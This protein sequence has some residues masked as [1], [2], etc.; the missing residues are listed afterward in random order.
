MVWN[1]RIRPIRSCLIQQV[2]VG[3]TTVRTAPLSQQVRNFDSKIPLVRG[4]PKTPP[5]VERIPPLQSV[6]PLV[7]K[8]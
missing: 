4:P 7:P 2:F 8:G 6:F 1:M 3:N 5:F